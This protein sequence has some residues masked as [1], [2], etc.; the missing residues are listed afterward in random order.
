M[1]IHP[2]KIDIAML[3]HPEMIDYCG[4]NLFKIACPDECPYFELCRSFDYENKY[5]D[6]VTVYPFEYFKEESNEKPSR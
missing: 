3:K 5:G 2:K 4:K 6:K 1:S